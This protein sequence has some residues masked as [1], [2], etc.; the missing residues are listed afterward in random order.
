MESANQFALTS[1]FFWIKIESLIINVYKGMV[2][3]YEQGK[4]GSEKL[5]TI[6]QHPSI[7][8]GKNLKPPPK[9][10]IKISYPLPNTEYHA[11]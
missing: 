1:L 4:V 2:I 8:A 5:S 11:D 3:I 7:E 6:S 10:A 9:E